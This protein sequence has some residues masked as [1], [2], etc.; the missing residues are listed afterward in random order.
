M[1]RLKNLKTKNG[2]AS[3]FVVIIT[4]IL[5]GVVTLGFTR[6]ILSEATQ[7][8]N[9]D[10]SQ[11]AYDS[12]LAG[13]EDAKIA[14]LEYY[15]CK[16]SATGCSGAIASIETNMD[17]KNCDV[18]SEALG[19]QTGSNEETII[20]EKTTSGTD[21]SASMEQAYT[22]VTINDDLEDYRTTLNSD[23]RLRV[24]PIK[25]SDPNAVKKVKV[26][27]FSDFNRTD[28]S[29]TI[30]NWPYK[31]SLPTLDTNSL[32][33]TPSFLGV[34]LFQTDETF[35]LSELSAANNSNQTDLAT[36]YLAPTNEGS[37]KTISAS[38]LAKTAN[39]ASENTTKKI[40]CADNG[41]NTNNGFYCTAT[42][43]LPQPFNGGNRNRDTFFLIL[44]LP[45]GIPETDV[46]V[47]LLD[48]DGHTLNFKGVQASIDSTGRANDLYR[49]VETRV[50]LVDTSLPYP[51][52]AIQMTGEG[53]ADN[54]DIKK[55]LYVTDNCW[56]A[57]NGTVADCAN[58]GD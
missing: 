45:Y 8:S 49:R 20:Q 38:E 53:G 33:D 47:A 14:L 37:K 10:L 17:G 34:Q 54:G 16:N 28:P 4:I 21:A 22:C 40:R 56:T 30:S 18:V 9:N 15:N 43:T 36:V 58:N 29:S 3:L 41:S 5:L 32:S 26:Q 6:L 46:A 24:V 42:L 44:S 2:A 55:T 11:S 13:V 57:S 52:F 12:A 25:T 51:E 39:K 27:W 23:N 35:S 31:N 7:T 50:D 1:N 48:D 19:R